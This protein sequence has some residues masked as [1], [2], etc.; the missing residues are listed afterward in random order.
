MRPTYLEPRMDVPAV[1]DWSTPPGPR[2]VRAAEP[3]STA[4]VFDATG[5]TPD[6]P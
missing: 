6:N 4:A 3:R 5:T 1:D 2:R